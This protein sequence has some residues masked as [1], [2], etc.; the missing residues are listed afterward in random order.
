[1]NILRGVT[2][3]FAFFLWVASTTLAVD[4][5]S[6]QSALDAKKDT[7]LSSL[8]TTLGRV[9]TLYN[10]KAK[11][12]IET[13]AFKGVECLGYLNG[14][15]ADVDISAIKSEYQKAILE[16]YVEVSADIR[17]YAVG[18]I[19]NEQTISGDIADFASSF[20]GQISSI[21]ST[22]D[23]TYEKLKTDFMNYYTPNKDLV[24]SLAEKI[25]SIDTVQEKYAALLAAQSG[26]NQ[27]LDFQTALRSAL[28][29]PKKS[30]S[31]LLKGDIDDLIIAYQSTN[32]EISVDKMEAER[33]RLVAEFMMEVDSFLYDLFKTD[34]D[35]ALYLKTLPKVQAFLDQYRTATSYQCGDLLATKVNWE[36][37]L[38][39]LE[40]SLDTLIAGFT[41]ARTSVERWDVDQATK[42]KT[43]F[44]ALYQ[45]VYSK[46]LTQK[47]NTFM[48]YAMALISEA[49]YLKN[50]VAD[51]N[52]EAEQEQVA[53]QWTPYL[54]T[55][56]YNKNTSAP[57]LKYLQEFL[58]AKGLYT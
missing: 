38:L 14:T 32:P 5:T 6:L 20:V 27:E 50:P 11:N 3:G 9:Q 48:S 36:R 17:R 4:V 51:T 8:D 7:L 53:V 12:L 19:T 33:D 29:A 43:T 30:A 49:Y 21:E 56:S 54:F 25:Q 47:R 31:N 52:E 23:A 40:N 57:E 37:L 34:I 39:D 1:M 45:E 10:N 18:L 55:K 28:E 44:L 16:K 2:L 35:Y 46:A 15:S 22:Y 24:L 26:F 13:S 42:V 58:T 41:K